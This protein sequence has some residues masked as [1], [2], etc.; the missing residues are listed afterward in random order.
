VFAVFAGVAMWLTYSSLG[1][2][3]K[4]SLVISGILGY[5]G[6][7]SIDLL[8]RVILMKV[9]GLSKDQVEFTEKADSDKMEGDTKNVKVG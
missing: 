8:R 2:E 9:L 4:L 5:F 3:V 7:S 6:P 1:I